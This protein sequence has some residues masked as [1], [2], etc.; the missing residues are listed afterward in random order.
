MIPSHLANSWAINPR[1]EQVSGQPWYAL[2][3][4]AY[5]WDRAEQAKIV[6][7]QQQFTPAFLLNTTPAPTDG[8][9]VVPA[10]SN[11]ALAGNER[12]LTLQRVAQH[13]PAAY[14]QYV[15]TLIDQAHLFGIDPAIIRGM[16]RPILIRRLQELETTDLDNIRRF[17]VESNQVLTQTLPPES[18]AVALAKQVRSETLIQLG[19]ALEHLGDDATL[20]DLWNATTT[21]RMLI[22]LLQNDGV[23]TATNLHRFVTAFGTLTEQGK[24]LLENLLLGT[25]VP[26]IDL[27]ASLP[28][29]LKLKLLKAL[30]P[31]TMIRARG[32]DWDLTPKVFQ[33]ARIVQQML[34]NQFR[35]VGEYLAQGAL[36]GEQ[37]VADPT[38]E[39]LATALF[40]MKPTRFREAL[41]LYAAH[42]MRDVAFQGV[43]P[44]AP[45]ALTPSEAFADA[46]GGNPGHDPTA[47]LF[48]IHYA[49]P[50]PK[51]PITLEQ[52]TQIFQDWGG[53]V[54]QT[55][56]GSVAV[57][58]PH[59]GTLVIRMVQTIP[60]TDE[61]D[62]RAF[63]VAYGQRWTPEMR[64]LGQEQTFRTGPHG[65]AMISLVVGEATPATLTHEITHFLENSGLLTPEEIGRLDLA[66]QEAGFGGGVEGRA[67][68]VMERLNSRR[69]NPSSPIGRILDA[70][71]DVLDR[72]LRV[73]GIRTTRGILRQIETGAVLQRVPL[74]A[75]SFVPTFLKAPP[76]TEMTALDHEA[77]LFREYAIF[78]GAGASPELLSVFANST[79]A[80]IKPI[81][82]ARTMEQRARDLAE[83]W[84]LDPRS[85]VKR[86]REIQ[87]TGLFPGAIE[88]Q[89][90]RAIHSAMIYTIREQL[91]NRKI[92]QAQF[93]LAMDTLVGG[94]SVLATLS[95]AATSEFGRGL[96]FA[97]DA[98][99]EVRF[100]ELLNRKVRDN[101]MQP[102][103]AQRLEE[104][105][106]EAI[107]TGDLDQV[108]ALFRQVDN[109]RFWDYL[110]EYF[111][112]SVLIGL[113]TLSVNA[114]SNLIWNLFSQT[115]LRA[116]VVS[117][118]R[119]LQVHTLRGQ[120]ATRFFQEI[121]P[122]LIGIKD[123]VTQRRLGGFLPG[124]A[125]RERLREAG[126]VLLRGPS[127]VPH[128][129]QLSKFERDI[130]Q[131][132]G[133]WERAT[134]NLDFPLLQR[135]GVPQSAITQAQHF[136]ERTLNI[137]Q[138]EPIQFMRWIAGPVT[139]AM[140]ILF[141]TDLL[142]RAAAVDA[143]I[144]ARA[145]RQALHENLTG[146]LRSGKTVLE[147]QIEL[148]TNPP[149]G[150]MD[151]ALQESLRLTF[152]DKVSPVA[153]LILQGRKIP[154]F[155][156]ALHMLLP[157]VGTPDRLLA[158]GLELIPIAGQFAFAWSRGAT[159][160][161]AYLTP[162]GAGRFLT[163]LALSAMMY[164][165][166]EQGVITGEPPD[167]PDERQSFFRRGLQPYAILLGDT[168]IPWRRF[169]P[170]NLVMA[171]V[172]IMGDAIRKEQ[173][174][175]AK[176]G[177]ALTLWNSIAIASVAGQAF[178]HH[179]IDGSYFHGLSLLFDTR[180]FGGGLDQFFQMG[181]DAI[182]PYAGLRRNITRALEAS[183]TGRG[184]I[185]KSPE[186]VF[187]ALLQNI[188]GA[189]AAVPARQTP[190]GEPLTIPGAALSQFVPF[191]VSTITADRVEQE[192]AKH[193][194][195]PGLPT[196]ADPLT[197]K[198]LSHRA[199]Q[200]LVEERG[201]RI[202]AEVERVINSSAYPFLAPA[203]RAERLRSAIRIASRQARKALKRRV[204]G[205]SMEETL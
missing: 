100:R 144:A 165:L 55:T 44:G 151:D 24:H 202:R 187:Q 28:Q 23:I 3:D 31:L 108:A 184:P 155:G 33:A 74:E 145:T 32:G 19:S 71:W 201:A 134:W 132:A 154:V 137:K 35:S 185:V 178:L 87:H 203:E 41:R 27:L 195:F 167:N 119:L 107:R 43:L 121:L 129:Q 171:V 58:T 62:Q 70:I 141:A 101:Q 120:P 82:F 189:S 204:E 92:T 181:L 190:F 78:A 135:A 49:R 106:L 115:V 15:Q 73:V 133:A 25:V 103:Q 110:S 148:A 173:D 186:T 163:G 193:A 124:L 20:A 183:Q 180:G 159:L 147:R 13:N 116:A 69:Y 104:Q 99:P 84:L 157:F 123:P 143:E 21:V 98:P 168:V 146:Q 161:D 114:L 166:W 199:F 17:T 112:G 36:F 122:A 182:I 93:D 4:R 153:K 169:E 30:A 130:G 34:A 42:A 45:P 8:P 7:Q 38:T 68:F 177:E 46:F 164:A 170:M 126:Q 65:L 117:G 48:Q 37:A 86:L 131:A 52:V 72:L 142:T 1:F 9:P 139:L 174:A 118:E 57:R 192:L 54:V 14:Q 83:R 67:N 179:I 127:A 109:P 194:V 150:M 10:D 40:A 97:Q 66:A 172:P 158:R 16:Q 22:D 96:R 51:T 138:G 111:Y 85:F 29:Q 200:F 176:Q 140:R 94:N 191:R 105:L 125:R 18:E 91:T 196:R 5:H 175:F 128:L 197:G 56:E 2:Q 76:E 160:K 61:S 26:D 47:S 63:E 79:T 136:L 90:I 12:I 188:P 64:I 89:A 59:N 113:P 102:A 50:I 39:M 149:Q 77:K 11:L 152:M 156:K 6:R 80:Y 162:E 95:A 60:L 198:A 81:L 53:E 88:L 205:L 75:R